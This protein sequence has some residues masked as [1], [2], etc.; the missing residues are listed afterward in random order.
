MVNG[1]SGPL[2]EGCFYFG[3]HHKQLANFEEDLQLHFDIFGILGLKNVEKVLHLSDLFF[4]IFGSF[5]Q[6]SLAKII[7][8]NL[9]KIEKPPL[10]EHQNM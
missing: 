9:A 1:K 7:A 3:N 10:W 5:G 2:T 8:K 6:V 4:S